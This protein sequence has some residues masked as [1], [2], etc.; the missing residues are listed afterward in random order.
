MKYEVSFGQPIDSDKA[1]S[2]GP[3]NSLRVA[4]LGDFSGR[5]N[6]GNLSI[7]DE[8]AKRKPHRV[9]VDNLD[10]VLAR[11]AIK[12]ALPIAN[13]GG[14]VNVS[15]NSMDDFHPDELYDRLQ[16]F[17]KLSSLR[18]RLQNSSS[19]EGAA[20]V[21]KSLLGQSAIDKQQSRKRKSSSTTVPNRKFEDFESIINETRSPNEEAPIVDLLKQVVGSFVIDD[22]DPQQDQFIATVDEAV[23]DTMR[24][25]LHHPDF[26]AMESLWRSV[27]LMV[28]R[29]ETG[30]QLHLVLYDVTAEELAADLSASD[31]L[32]ES[33][34]FRMLVEQ[35]SLD[36]QQGPLSLILGS[37]VFEQTPPHADLLGRMSQIANAAHAPFIASISNDCLKKKSIEEVHPL[38]KESWDALKSHPNSAYLMLTVPNFMLRWPYGKKSDPIDPFEFEEFTDR[39]GVSTMLWANGCFLAGLLLCKTCQEQGKSSMKLGSFMTM[40]D[41]PFYYYV[42]EYGD[43]IPF[44]CTNRL[45]SESLV[46]HV[47][48]Q[49][50]APVIGIKGRPEVRLGSFKSLFG[51]LLTGSWGD[52]PDS[53]TGASPSP[54]VQGETDD[55]DSSSDSDMDAML[56]DDSDSDSDSDSDLSA[57]MNEMGDDSDSSDEDDDL[58]ALLGS[59]D[60]DDDDD[61]EMDPELAALLND[62]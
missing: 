24:R 28:R 34:L 33:G 4:I 27:E 12:L 37:Y 62:M 26:Q 57:L 15:L 38:V 51:Q 59:M 39:G 25:V 19:F 60:S 46:A 32:E 54:V 30:N 3:E 16:V 31:N 41:L 50:F 14:I 17:E 48:S 58:A 49:N 23:S 52:R 47:V 44:P 53:S 13:D 6:T 11:F 36:A 61:D 29:L 56:S 2:H 8:L 5:A 7:G 35:P 22:P 21:V 40:D 18:S 1:I 43:Q 9:D 45:L 10:D 20:K 55:S 42:D